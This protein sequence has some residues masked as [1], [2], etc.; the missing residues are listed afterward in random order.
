MDDDGGQRRR[1]RGAPR[2][3]RGHAH[4]GHRGG[5]GQPHGQ[6]HQERG[7][8]RQGQIDDNEEVNEVV[9]PVAPPREPPRRRVHIGHTALDR[10]LQFA[11]EDL[12][13]HV[14]NRVSI[15]TLTFTGMTSLNEYQT[16]C[17][18]YSETSSRDLS[19]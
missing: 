7:G 5:R 4:R 19:G 13:L 1:G 18:T 10:M 3:P 8:R 14:T 9:E 6:G 2:R 16:K 11:P 17:L 12:L 15:M